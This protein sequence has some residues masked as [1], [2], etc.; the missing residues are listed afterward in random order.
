M[1]YT[2]ILNPCYAS[3]YNGRVD[4]INTMY[5]ICT[6]GLPYFKPMS[7]PPKLF[8]FSVAIRV[9]FL[10]M[11]PGTWKYFTTS[12]VMEPINVTAKSFF[13]GNQKPFIFRNIAIN[14]FILIDEVWTKFLKISYA[15]KCFRKVNSLIFFCIFVIT[16]TTDRAQNLQSN[17]I[18]NSF[19]AIWRLR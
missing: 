5:L 8:N 10:K 4:Y 1:H 13:L 9:I 7:L 18:C 19:S 6:D 2:P 17:S 3:D 11:L 16:T 14:I 15:T 12:S